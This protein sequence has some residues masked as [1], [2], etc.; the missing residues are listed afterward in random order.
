MGSLFEDI[1]GLVL[2]KIQ[3]KS[4][5][6]REYLIPIAIGSLMG[7]KKEPKYIEMDVFILYVELMPGLPIAVSCYYNGVISPDK[8]RCLKQ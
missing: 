7:R 6:Q 4:D 5:I 8:Q 3:S 1:L 2:G